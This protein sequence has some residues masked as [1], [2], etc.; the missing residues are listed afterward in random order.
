MRDSY[1]KKFSFQLNAEK[2]GRF[3]F[4]VSPISQ[5]E[6]NITVSILEMFNKLFKVLK[7]PESL[8]ILVA[9]PAEYLQVFLSAAPM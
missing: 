3:D 6:Q 4:I 5:E 8:V 1:I 7:N 9:D 2:D